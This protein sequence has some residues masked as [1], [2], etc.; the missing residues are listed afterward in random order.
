M[1]ARRLCRV[2]SEPSKAHF[3]GRGCVA[4]Y[5]GPEHQ[6]VCCSSPRRTALARVLMHCNAHA[7][8]TGAST[9][10][11]VRVDRPQRRKLRQNPAAAR[12]RKACSNSSQPWKRLREGYTASETHRANSYCHAF[13]QICTK[14]HAPPPENLSFLFFMPLLMAFGENKKTPN[15]GSVWTNRSR[16]HLRFG[17]RGGGK[18]SYEVSEGCE[19]WRQTLRG[20]GGWICL[21]VTGAH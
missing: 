21:S 5:C 16:N 1:D 17:L 6:K 13:Q 2:C 15:I 14:R 7:R 18:S 9:S 10:R 3:S 4:Y 19:G 12:L 20:A 11:F 8:R